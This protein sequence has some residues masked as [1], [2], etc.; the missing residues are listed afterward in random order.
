VRPPAL[1]I[2]RA[3]HARGI[4]GLAATNVARSPG[5][6]LVGALGLAAGIA[7]LTVL[8]S[9]TTA[10]RGVVVGSLLGNAIA[11]QVRGIDYVAV[12]ATVALG[13]LAVADVVFLNISERATELATIRSFGWRESALAQ[14]VV[15]EG[16]LIGI[17]GSVT[18]AVA[19]L[20]AAAQF[21][22]QLPVRLLAVAA[23]A[24]AVGVLATAAAAL[25]P[26]QLLRRLPAAH[27][28]AEE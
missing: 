11:V 26:S 20:A 18:G 2:R 13:V 16:V 15:T 10:F 12:G 4:T 7:A 1:A 22:G 21:A 23:A 9:V 17:A 6:T 28:L 14:L 25:F 5:R 27:L 8:I 19:G 3:R 24:V